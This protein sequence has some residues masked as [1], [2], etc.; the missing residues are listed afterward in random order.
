MNIYI[1]SIIITV[2]TII[3][4]IIAVPTH[5]LTPSQ[6]D[7]IT[8]LATY[9]AELT[10]TFDPQE[11][12]LDHFYETN[13]DDII[14]YNN[15]ATEIRNML[16]IDPEFKDLSE[17]DKY[18]AFFDIV[19]YQT[20][21]IIKSN[22]KPRTFKSFK[23]WWE[24]TKTKPTED[25]KE[26]YCNEVERSHKISEKD[27]TS[28]LAQIEYLKFD[29][30][31]SLYLPNKSLIKDNNINDINIPLSEHHIIPV[32]VLKKFFDIYYSIKKQLGIEL[33]TKNKYNWYFIE[34][35]N[36]R[37]DMIINYKKLFSINEKE[38]PNFTRLE[39]KK[40]YKKFINRVSTSPL[41]FTFRGPQLRSDD[42][43]KLNPNKNKVD[44]NFEYG[45]A[46]I[47]GQKYFD[48]MK[49][50]YE[51]I[52]NFNKDQSTLNLQEKD[53]EGTRLY[54]KIFNI[55][56]ES[57][58]LVYFYNPNFW[59]QD[60]ENK[61]LNETTWH[62]GQNSQQW[63]YNAPIGEWRLKSMSQ[64]EDVFDQFQ[65]L[66]QIHINPFS[67]AESNKILRRKRDITDFNTSYS[68][69]CSNITISSTTSVPSTTT[70]K[71]YRRP[72]VCRP[73]NVWLMLLPPIH[74]YC[75]LGGYYY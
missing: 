8:K 29:K 71:P 50:L 6:L 31:R 28:A 17:I 36:K 61:P 13:E 70:K 1:L 33:T 22:R 64:M 23:L 37:K 5:I 54:N 14:A 27:I 35:H 49:K 20:N 39:N 55:H 18:E 42:P 46:S 62:I 40:E 69:A 52:R 72:Y 75:R 66:Q 38:L 51:E 3:T 45:C 73:E 67:I 68:I 58:Q 34:E 63:V 41:G 10:T 48:K 16:Y 57:D 26:I 60:D 2:T 32:S 11:V 15:I 7:A 65:L 43:S 4:S 24:L 74:V 21:L 59:V 25:L 9:Y 44:D 19:D 12:P 56:L 30:D 53:R 47:I